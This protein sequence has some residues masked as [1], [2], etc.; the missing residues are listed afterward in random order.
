MEQT[1]FAQPHRDN[2]LAFWRVTRDYV[3][4][5]LALYYSDDAAVA[6]DAALARWRARL[7]DLLPSGLTDN[8]GWIGAGPLDRMTLDRIAAI[9]LHT[10][11][12]THD[13]VN[14]VVWNYSTLNFLIPTVVPESGEL[15]DRRL[16]FDFIT[17]LIGTWKRY[18]MLLDGISVL[19]LDPAARALMD[20]YIAKLRQLDA[21]AEKARIPDF[22]YARNLNPSVS[23]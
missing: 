12:V 21:G 16:S 8:T 19:A 4:D 6:A 2:L 17:T 5:Y 14:N 20:G 15:Q 10:S 7:D 22:T 11:T 3:R 18:N 13:Q 9:F 1:P 23:N